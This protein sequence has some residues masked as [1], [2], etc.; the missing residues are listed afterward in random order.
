LAPPAGVSTPT[1]ETIKAARDDVERREAGLAKAKAKRAL[2]LWSAASF[3]GLVVCAILGLGLVE[4]IAK[5]RPES[6][7]IRTVDVLLTGLAVGAG[8]KPL[9]DLIARIEKAK[10]NADA[11]ATPSSLPSPS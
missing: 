5:E 11:A 7:F 2:L 9:H 6:E 8:T 10:D 4:A 3:L 1:E